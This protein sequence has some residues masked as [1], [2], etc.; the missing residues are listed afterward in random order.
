MSDRVSHAQD[1]GRRVGDV[2]L[3]FQQIVL[4]CLDRQIAG[5][6]GQRAQQLARS[7]D[8][9][10]LRALA[11]ERNGMH[12]EACTQVDYLRPVDPRQLQRVDLVRAGL[13]RCFG[14]AGHPQVD[15]REMACV[16]LRDAGH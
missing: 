14:A 8:R 7:V 16:V 2:P 12:A 15:G 10:D 5:Q 1:C 9:S 13:Q 3:K 11:R 6:C 4:D